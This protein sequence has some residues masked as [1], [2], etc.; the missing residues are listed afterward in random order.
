[1]FDKTF[2]VSLGHKEATSVSL[3]ARVTKHL[4]FEGALIFSNDLDSDDYHNRPCPSDSMTIIGDKKVEEG[5]GYDLLYF[6]GLTDRFSLF[7]GIGFYEQK[8][9]L[10]SR[11]DYGAYYAQST[12]TDY[13]IARSSGI[14][15]K[16]ND[17]S[18]LGLS[19]HELRGINLR[20]GYLFGI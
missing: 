13:K 9:A 17:K 8:C 4:G 1:M 11:S 18:F 7:I 14:Q 20:W 3:G 5:K 6:F 15:F 10:I 2:F 16:Y 12:Y 19:Y